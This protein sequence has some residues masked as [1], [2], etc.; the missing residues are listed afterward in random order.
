MFQQVQYYHI[1]IT[2]INLQNIK[3]TFFQGAAALASIPL[4]L[5]LCV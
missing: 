3:E 5:R 2:K 1:I 4:R